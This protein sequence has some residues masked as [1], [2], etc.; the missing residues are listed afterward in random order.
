MPL[1]DGPKTN[2][3]NEA[4]ARLLYQFR[5]STNFRAIVSVFA[6]R[7]QRIEAATW[8]VITLRLFDNAQGYQ[9]YMLG[10]LVGVFQGDLSTEAFKREIACAIL[11]IRAQGDPDV[12]E[13]VAELALPT[14][15]QFLYVEHAIGTVEIR[16]LDP[17]T[18]TDALQAFRLI[19]QAR[20]GGVRLM[21]DW[22]AT[23]NWPIF[24]L[25][26]YEDSVRHNELGLA[27]E[28]NVG[29][30]LREVEST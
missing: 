13:R 22:S 8:E 21:V 27:D 12:I 2:Y 3:E 20:A 1:P 6:R 28:D 23:L 5:N 15:V 14:D 11:L 10:R 9:L 25:A 30:P 16:V 17:I 19:K 29:A 24:T 18:T 4:R 7:L 26:N